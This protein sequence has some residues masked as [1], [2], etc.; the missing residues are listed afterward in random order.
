M[1]KAIH[2]Q[3]GAK[4]G[5]SKLPGNLDFVLEHAISMVQRG[6]LAMAEPYFRQILAVLPE[7]PDALQFLGV[8]E[9]QKGRFEEAVQLLRLAVSLAPTAHGLHC[10]LGLALQHMG[11][12]EAALASYDRALALNQKFVEALNNRGNVLRD[13]NRLDE[14]AASYQRALKIRPDFAEAMLNLGI[15]FLALQQPEAALGA[16]AGC[17]RANPN[18]I[19][20]LGQY[21][22]GLLALKRPVDALACFEKILS[23]FPNDAEGHYWRGNTLL[24]MRK[25]DDAILS[26]QKAAQLR[27]DIPE[28]HYNLG[29][30]LLDRG[31]PEDA[32]LAFQV[33]LKLRPDYVEALYNLGG[34]QQELYRHA[35]AAQTYERLMELVPG[36]RYTLGKLH[37]CQQY[38]ADWSCH[39]E[40]V[41]AL[42]RASEAGAPREMPFPFLS[43]T[44]DPGLQLRCAQAFTAS[45]YPSAA[46]PLSGGQRSSH[47]RIRIAYVSADFGEHALSY[48][49]AG[50]FEAHDRQR[51]ETVGIA[52]KTLDGSAMGARVAAA[53]ERF[54]DVSGMSD[55][56]AA[57]LMRELEVDIAVDLTGYTQNNRTEIFALRPAPVQVNYLGYPGTMGADFIDYIIADQF[58]IPERARQHY[59][60]QIAYLPE[61]FQANDDKRAVAERVPG[62]AELGL[63]ESG[64]VFCAFN[65]TYKLTPDF[66]A[67]WMRLLDAVP[68]SVLWFADDNPDVQQN[69]RAEAAKHGVAPQRL[70]FSPRIKYADHLARLAQA[71]LFLDTLP[72]NAGTTASDALWA[73]VPVL[74]CAGEAFSARMAGSLLHAMD[75][76]E[77]VTHCLEDYERQALSLASNPEKL[78]ELRN[79]L[80]SKRT[81]MPLFNTA[82]FCRHLEAA[83]ENMWARFQRGEAPMSFALAPIDDSLSARAD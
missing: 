8:I 74:T 51:F 65:N 19:G 75:L 28:V 55:G 10:N 11:Q 56:E 34:A 17:L 82:R 67:L 33:A 68:D 46:T 15:T 26:Y 29:N 31:R 24:A 3:T 42:V 59:A 69:L 71:D 54:V 45:K 18:H 64:L 9:L 40:H 30:V 41:E 83:F 63:P 72:F 47:D 21:G 37:Y 79:R 7:H 38:L 20:A 57:S 14:A 13:L 49:M 35:D 78:K 43:I 76:P 70:V 62:R 5:G 12:R 60:E 53:F 39:T 77:L 2:R 52:L 48:L 36:H 25:F 27:P 22:I 73:G 23:D 44:S 32:S 16:L 1:N 80:A 6:Q 66:F 81:T 50:V 61:C 58:V 4:V